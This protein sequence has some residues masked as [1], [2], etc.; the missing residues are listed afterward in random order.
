MGSKWPGT[1]EFTNMCFTCQE[2]CDPNFEDDVLNLDF[3]SIEEFP[4]TLL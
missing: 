4:E 1:V 2:K 3:I